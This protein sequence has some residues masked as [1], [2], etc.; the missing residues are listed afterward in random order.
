MAATA[1][2]VATH[3][4]I[5]QVIPAQHL[6]AVL[7]HI[8]EQ[9][10]NYG[11]RSNR[12]VGFAHWNIDFTGA[13]S[14]NGLDI[15]RRLPD[16]MSQ[17]WQ[18]LQTTRFPDTV[19]LRC[20]TN[21]HTYGVEG[22][23]HT[24]SIRPGE[25][26]LVIYLNQEWRREWGGETMIYDGQ[27]VT[28]AELPGFNRGLVF[29]SDQYHCAR[30]VTRICPA[31][32]ITLMFKF[33]ARDADLTRDRLQVFL[34]QHGAQ[35]R[36]HSGRSLMNHLLQVYDLLRRRGAA[37]PVCLAGGSHSVF[38]TGIYQESLLTQD[39][40]SDLES[41]IGDKAIQLVNW[42]R[43]LDRPRVLENWCQNP[44]SPITTLEGHRVDLDPDVISQLCL[45]EC[46]NLEDQKSLSRYSGLSRFWNQ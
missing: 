35:D 9:G 25:R 28:H 5:E 23:P 33:A 32:R 38:G 34:E 7:D 44:A 29:D 19:L 1:G 14:S 36:P 2:T 37:D 39:Q 15:S 10:W 6:D 17:L 46:A 21:S 40:H 20:Y 24:D 42:F 12:G 4:Q 26:T 11:W 45:I 27:Q 16:C 41:V 13:D 18:H 31:Q 43:V 30:G 8:K 22:Y 3:N